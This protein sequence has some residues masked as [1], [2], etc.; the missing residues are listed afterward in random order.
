MR[1]VL[2]GVMIWVGCLHFL[3]PEPFISIVPSYLPAHRALVLISG[4]FEALGGLGLLVPR[5]RRAAAVGL[6]A[7][8]LAVFPANVFMATHHVPINGQ[9]FSSLLL[10]LR[11]PLQFVLIAWAWWVRRD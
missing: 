10:W 3:H 1:V 2:A 7:L 5:V 8:Y 4:F 9:H 6:I 11:L